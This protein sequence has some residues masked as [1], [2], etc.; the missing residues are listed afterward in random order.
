MCTNDTQC[1]PDLTFLVRGGPPARISRPDRR[2]RLRTMPEFVQTLTGCT[3]KR[4]HTARVHDLN[5]CWSQGPLGAA[6]RWGHN[7][8]PRHNGS[9]ARQ[10]AAETSVARFADALEDAL[11]P[12]HDAGRGDALRIVRDERA[13]I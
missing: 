2:H 8:A 11:R 5:S 6:S 9:R 13:G 4:L 12:V 7:R 3:S 10:G 1:V